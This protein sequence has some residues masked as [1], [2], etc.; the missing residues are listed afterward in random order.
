MAGIAAYQVGCSKIPAFGLF[1]HDANDSPN[2]DFSS[3]VIARAKY[4]S[5]ILA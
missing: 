3:D 2:Y 1:D 5:R 4:Y